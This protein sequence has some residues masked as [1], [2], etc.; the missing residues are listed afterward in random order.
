MTENDWKMETLYGIV[1]MIERLGNN[2]YDYF[3]QDIAFL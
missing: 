1:N 2:K 3:M